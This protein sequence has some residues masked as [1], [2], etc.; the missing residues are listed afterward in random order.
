MNERHY[1]VK[2]LAELWHFSTKT[3]RNLFKNEPG[4]LMLE[5]PGVMQ[6]KHIHMTLSIPESV[7][8]RVYGRLKQPRTTLWLPKSKPV[9]RI[10]KLRT[11][12]DH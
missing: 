9:R 11:L 6:G 4:V 12:K 1:S 5:G 8:L 7:A 2:E 3:V 10:I